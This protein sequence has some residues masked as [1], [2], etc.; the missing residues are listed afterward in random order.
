MLS[1]RRR[2]WPASV[3]A[4]AAVVLIAPAAPAQPC[5][6]G[7]GWDLFQ[8]GEG[9]FYNPL[10]DALGEAFGVDA[11][12]ISFR[13]VPLG[14]FQFE[15]FGIRPTGPTDTIVQRRTAVF[16]PGGPVPI[17]LVALQLQANGVGGVN[18]NAPLF[19]TLQSRRGSGPLD[20]PPGEQSTGVLN[21]QFRDC[22]SG[23]ADASFTVFF[24]VRAGSVTGPVLLSRELPLRTDPSG[25][26]S[27]P[28]QH[29]NCHPHTIRTG[30]H[31]TLGPATL[32]EGV[33]FLVPEG[34]F[35]LGSPLA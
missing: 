5:G 12:K 13:G 24:D 19:V 1:S 25:W 31:C 32:I 22:G 35:Y 20:P 26:T 15:D 21:I 4:L 7:A 2:A 27:V 3:L 28:Q 16:P 30:V 33:N 10:A 23:I 9:T 29:E 18:G 14:Q 17:E 8:T 11:S 34:D 6:V